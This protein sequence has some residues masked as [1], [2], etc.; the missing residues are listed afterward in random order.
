MPATTSP[1]GY[2]ILKN[3]SI[4][5]LCS[6]F[7]PLCTF[8]AV[9]S[10]IISPFTKISE[11]IKHHRLWRQ[12]SSRT[13]RPRTILVTGVGT[14]K[15]LSLARVFYRAGHRV[16]GADFEPYFVPVCGH[17]SKSIEVFYRLSRLNREVGAAEYIQDLLSIVVKEKVELWVSCSNVPA[18]NDAEAADMI[19][20][21]TK[22]KT[23]QFSLPLTKT[24]L[25]IWSFVSHARETKLNVPESHIVTSETEA[26][27]AIYS[28][29]PHEE[30]TERK[31][32]LSRLRLD[33]L[34]RNPDILLLPQ[35]L[36]ELE[37][38]L[39]KLSPTPS[40]PFFIQE[41]LP[42]LD[43]RTH[44]LILT[45]KVSAFVAYRSPTPRDVATAIY[46]PLPTTSTL[47]RALLLYTKTLINSLSSSRRPIAGHLSLTFRVPAEISQTAED[48]FGAPDSEV[49]E[50]MANIYAVS[51]TPTISTAA[52]LLSDE[53]EDLAERYLSILQGHEPLGIANG[54]R[55]PYQLI[56]PK[57]NVPDYY[58]A[59]E[60]LAVGVLWTL[61]GFLS[62]R[63]ELQEVW[64]RWGDVLGNLMLGRDTTWEMWDPWPFW[65][66][67]V[68]YWPLVHVG[69]IIEGIKWRGWAGEEKSAGD[70]LKSR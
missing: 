14:T 55:D 25:E 32:L 41:N 52:I 19:E 20:R 30:Q 69:R 4:I 16:I 18:V 64:R 45:S 5:L 63:I 42:G 2:H 40:N 7:I 31:Y 57:P 70:C 58:S 12:T 29:A 6:F 50:V 27:S 37:S 65:W 61:W 11:H 26:V 66:L 1:G 15:G 54:H 9:L 23:V 56:V 48:S 51:A 67:Y 53:S 44:T 33:P 38:L 10:T 68:V 59:G 60:Q 13:F 36:S 22:C 34:D 21:R 17:V 3:V 46:T 24:L 43:F 62:G 35:A 47:S 39:R 49:E 8:I 28:S